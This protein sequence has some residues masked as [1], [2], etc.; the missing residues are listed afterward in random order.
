MTNEMTTEFEAIGRDL[1]HSAIAQAYSP[2]DVEMG[3]DFSGL[4]DLESVE[5]LAA[6]HGLDWD[7]RETRDDVFAAVMQGYQEV[8]RELYA[9][10][11]SDYR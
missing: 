9:H 3:Y 7:D 4:G 8:V 6:R 1:A 2:H 5:T 10:L 11:P